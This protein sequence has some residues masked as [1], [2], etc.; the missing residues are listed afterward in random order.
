MAPLGG[1]VAVTKSLHPIWPGLWLALFTFVWASG[2]DIIYSTM[3]EVF[4]RSTGLR[5]LPARFGSPVAL[6]I[7]VCLHLFPFAAFAVLYQTYL[8]TPV[9]L[10]TLCA[11]VPLLYWD[12]QN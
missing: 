1:W 2:F 11:L 6:L 4:D 12:H 8:H 5:S 10:P 3:G 7:S 9:E